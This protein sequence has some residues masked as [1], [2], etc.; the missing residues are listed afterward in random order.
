M[1]MIEA[2]LK[3]M[4]KAGCPRKVNEIYLLMKENNL[5]NWP[6][7][8]PENSI[9]AAIMRDM[10]SSN[11]R[12]EKFGSNCF[13]L[14]EHKAPSGKKGYVYILSNPFFGSKCIK[15]GKA[16][17]VLER[18]ISLNSAVPMDYIP[19]YVLVSTA[20]EI[21]EDLVH[22]KLKEAGYHPDNY[23]DEFF[24]CSVSQAKK[25]LE[26]VHKS[27]PQGDNE[28]LKWDAGVEVRFGTVKK[29][30]IPQKY[31]VSCDMISVVGSSSVGKIK[32][33]CVTLH[34]N[35]TIS[36]NKSAETFLETIKYIGV[37][38]VA[39]VLPKR[40]SKDKKI[41]PSYASVRELGGGWFLNVHGSTNELAKL[42]RVVNSELKLGIEVK[43][44]G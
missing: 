37:D 35:V 40:I 22:A 16:E 38:R 32:K 3:A 24:E 18:L 28:I 5:W 36:K 39:A 6:T 20:Y 17:S 21:A 33:F 14:K 2:I 25:V 42:L 9:A 1:T 27:L 4:V 34:N 19:E 29:G 8:T 41:F 31:K 10:K 30:K 44:F 11:T 12:F 13:G 23:N 26:K 7:K 15:V 43:E